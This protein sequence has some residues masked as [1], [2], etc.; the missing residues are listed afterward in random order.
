[1]TTE[2]TGIPLKNVTHL[3]DF[4]N[5]YDIALVSN[6]FVAMY[7]K[8]EGLLNIAGQTDLQISYDKKMKIMRSSGSDN[9][10]LKFQE[11]T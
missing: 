6:N 5:D 8:I 7:K 11:R 4:D 1:M 2:N 3:E 9:N 10:A